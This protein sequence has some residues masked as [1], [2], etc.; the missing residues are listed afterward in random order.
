MGRRPQLTEF[1][2]LITPD[3]LT[4]NLHDGVGRFLISSS[5]RGMAPI[6]YITQKGPFQHGK[7]VKGYLLGERVLQLVHRRNGRNRQEQWDLAA[8]LLDYVRPNR[9]LSG[10][11]EPTILRKI[12]PNG[13]MRDLE[14]RIEQGPTFDGEP[15][16]WDEWS[17]TG[18]LRFIAADPTYYDPDEVEF[19]FALGA[20]EVGS[21]TYPAKYP[22]IYGPGGALDVSVEVD[23][24][25]TWPAF[26]II[27]ITGPFSLPQIINETTG[28][29]ISLNY[30]I[31]AGQMITIDLRYGQK[32]IYDN[33]VPPVILLGTRTS[34][35]NISTFHIA[36]APYAPGGVNTIHVLGS[37][38]SS[39]SVLSFVFNT[40]YIGI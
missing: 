26:P 25:G 27:T 12:L 36:E 28:E 11:F 37:E 32:T 17:I 10:A 20:S 29:Q 34:D 38:L 18:A 21:L 23:Y 5:G 1:D 7:T 9:G 33:S 6:E 30:T 24:D 14:V 13:Q 31:A 22:V 39:D 16:K 4:Y 35:S 40:H 8:E 15:D 19:D 3:G 2:E